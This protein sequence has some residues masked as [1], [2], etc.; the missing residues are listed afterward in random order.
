MN[1]NGLVRATH[2]ER[3]AVVY[4]RQSTAIQ[5]RL[6]KE[7]ARRQY[8]LKDVA[9][10]LGWPA[11]RIEVI[12]EDQGRSGQYADGRTGFQRLE[13]DVLHRRIGMLFSIEVSRLARCSAD[14]YRLL[15]YC[16]LADVLL[17]D[18]G[19]VY[20]PASPDDRMM[21]GLKGTM[22]E[23]E[24]HAIKERLQGARLSKARRGELF[25]PPPIGYEWDPRAGRLRW[26]SDERVRAAVQQVFERFRLIGTA[27]GVARYLRAHG[28]QMPAHGR[29]AGP[30]QWGPANTPQI[31][32]ILRNPL[33]AGHYVYGRTHEGTTLIDGKVHPHHRTEVPCGKWAIDL[34]DWHPAYLTWVQYEANQQRLAANRPRLGAQTHQGAAREG[35]ALLQGLLLCGRC[36]LRMSTVHQHRTTSYCCDAA[37]RE[38]ASR[39]RYWSIA[40]RRIDA[41]VTALLLETVAPPE[42][43]LTLALTREIEKQVD[44]LDRHWKLRLS[45]LQYEASLAERRY[46][47]VDPDNRVIARTLE[48]EWN[49]A[50]TSLEQAR[51]EHQQ[52]RQRQLLTLSDEDRARVREL[53]RDLRRVWEAPTTTHQER[54]T[55][56][57]LAIREIALQPIDVPRRMVRIKVLWQ[58]GAVQQWT[59]PRPGP[60][61]PTQARA[62]S[63]PTVG[64]S[65]RSDPP[66]R[67]RHRP[68]ASTGTTTKSS[69]SGRWCSTRDIARRFGVP[70]HTVYYWIR[71]RLLQAAGDTVPGKPGRYRLDHATRLRLERAK[72]RAY[73]ARPR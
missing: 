71:L 15:D 53:A 13:D 46:K 40:A 51:L 11:E 31:R 66:A 67:G 43:D 41:S 28:L 18:E 24:L 22:S 25:L 23:L 42:I 59:V 39:C 63:K 37:R 4:L 65:G 56:L 30:V 38:P 5:V 34:P 2:L 44:A 61:R 20:H 58:T 52:A 1:T 27:S 14:W 33:Y 45:Q 32:N 21:L 36:G 19:K 57:R 8:G 6:N 9:L 26:S 10:N 55:L 7:S 12:D 16:A 70:L 72:A 60:G 29:G 68:G 73:G 69:P 3:R 50:L 35:G 47:A 49:E 54:K 48:R 62:S 64:R 17:A